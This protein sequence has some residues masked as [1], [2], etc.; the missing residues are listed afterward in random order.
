MLTFK[1][2][3]TIFTPF[4]FVIIFNLQKSFKKGTRNL[5]IP[6]FNHFGFHFLKMHYFPVLILGKCY[7][8][9]VKLCT[10]MVPSLLMALL[11]LFQAV[12][13]IAKLRDH[14]GQ[15]LRHFQRKLN[16]PVLLQVLS[17][18]CKLPNEG[19]TYD[20]S[21]GGTNVKMAPFPSIRS[22]HLSSSMKLFRKSVKLCCCC[23]IRVKYSSESEPTAFTQ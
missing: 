11:K 4:Y 8:T 18:F 14:L 19:V 2:G 9:F 22:P 12:M 7:E 10:R 21:C 3:L 1:I 17:P 6:L 13:K 5:S 15:P 20:F 23:L 16:V